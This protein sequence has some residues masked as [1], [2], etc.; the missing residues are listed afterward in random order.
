MGGRKPQVLG[1]LG[2]ILALL[3]MVA[4]TLP[5][6]PLQMIAVR[7]GWRLARD[8]PVWW[9]GFALRRAGVTVTEEGA[10]TAG[11]PLLITPNHVSWLDVSVI[12]SRRPVSFVAKAEVATWPL[13]GLFAVLQRCVFVDRTRRQATA[14]VA[15]EIGR[16]L[17]DGDAMVLFAEGTSSNGT[18]VRPF[19]SALIGA[20]GS[21]LAHGDHER[22]WVQPMAILY[23]GLGGLPTG[24]QERIR[25]AWYGDMELVPSL[26]TVFTGPPLD[27]TVVWGDPLPLDATS[28]RKLAARALERTVRHLVNQGVA[29]RSYGTTALPAP[30]PGRAL[31]PMDL[32]PGAEPPAS[33]AAMP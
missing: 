7:R 2:A 17:A 30:S 21:A 3:A 31:A 22:V 12:A 20:A 23:R 28:D 5:A 1:V 18:H 16:R 4:V 8:L 33:V 19:R 10:P 6:L 26:W 15:G 9:H 11:R 13:F 32:K 24:R 29:G 27:V 14:K 25:L